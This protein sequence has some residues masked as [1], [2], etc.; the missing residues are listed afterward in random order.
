LLAWESLLYFAG[1]D[2]LLLILRSVDRAADR[3]ILAYWKS[4]SPIMER[5]DMDPTLTKMSFGFRTTGDDKDADT[6]VLAVVIVNEH[7]VAQRLD[8]G[9]GQSDDH[10]A[11]DVNNGNNGPWDLPVN[12]HPLKS[13]LNKGRYEVTITPNGNDRWVFVA[14]LRAEFSDGTARNWVLQGGDVEIKK[15]LSGEFLANR[16]TAS[17]NLADSPHD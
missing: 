9:Q 16:P 6:S 12:E 14:Y 1:L 13:E 2:K 8:F 15:N 3:V 17:W 10:F 4:L 11:N 7:A 5:Q